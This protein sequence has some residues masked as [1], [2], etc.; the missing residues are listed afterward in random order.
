ME[1]K[2]IADRLFVSPETVKGHLKNIYQK[3][4][5]NNRREGA[6]EAEKIGILSGCV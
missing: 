6:E 4:E 2:E 1:N 3:L 5:V